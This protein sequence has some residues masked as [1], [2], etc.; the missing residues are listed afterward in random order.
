MQ[1]A[2]ALLKRHG[3]TQIAATLGYLPDAV[4]DYF[5]GG[6]AF[7][8]E[9]RYYV[10]QVP[11]GTA[12]GVR[13]AAD[14]LDET[15]I[16]LSGDGVTDLDIAAA[17]AF[18]RKRRALAT[19]V[20]KHAD[21]P[22][23]Y[24]V[25][26]TDPDG[27]V[28]SFHEKP[29]WSDAIS[30][31]VNT[32]IYI[33]E[34]QALSYIPE[35]R[36]YDFGHDLF[37]ELVR[38]GLPVYGYVTKDY[39]CDVGD[40]RAYLAVHQDALEGRIRVEGLTPPSNRAFQ[41]A[42]ARVDRA[43]VLEGPCLIGANV[44]V[45]P[46]AYVGPY[47]VIGPD[48]V[49][50][51]GASVKRSV[52]WQGARLE[53]GAQARGC[54]LA[55][56]AVM[57]PGAQAYEESVLGTDASIGERALLMPGVKLWPGKHGA[58]GRRLESNLVWGGLSNAIFEGGAIRLL[59]PTQAVRA[60]QAVASALD[61]R[62][63]LLGRCAG[64]WAEALW[65][66]AASGAMAQ[67]ARVL[68]GG[69]CT[70]PQLRCLQALL[71]CDGALWVREDAL[72]PLNAAGAPLLNRDVRA[73]M[74][75]YDRQ[76]FREPSCVG[77]PTVVSVCPGEAAYIARATAWFTADPGRV[78]PVAI[79]A[80]DAQLAALAL[81]AF[82]R[83]GLS[84]RHAEDDETAL[85]PG[86]IGVRL[87]ED[88]E[89]WQLEDETGELSEAE[90]QLLV[91]WTALEL[92]EG[93]LLMPVQATRAAQDLAK[94]Y[95][96]RVEYVAGEGALWANALAERSPI[97]FTLQHD[98]IASALAAISAL[99]HANLTVADWRRSMPSVARRSLSVQVPASRTG[100]VLRAM[101]RQQRG[102]ELGGGLHFHRENGWAW[103]CPDGARSRFR[104]VTEAASEEYARELCDFC[105]KE[106]KRFA[107]EGK[108]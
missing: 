4:R 25:V 107:A 28:R 15:F 79:F 36:S 22:L 2:L 42:S 39:W 50:G 91:A 80:R 11:L 87:S 55:A 1:Y 99:A 74:A 48:C 102:A 66:A 24:G 8:V 73:I 20:L 45:L 27:R 26:L 69:V 18:H 43:A 17:A 89:G 7:G 54:V 12:G 62:E 90:Q 86:E 29:D 53:K 56:G 65:H 32:G 35:G 44:R 31:I 103:I 38:Q 21:N 23:D 85:A 51:E 92:G 30:D 13:Q 78:P 37:P 101:A 104:V 76:D 93:A 63:L 19:L 64:G 57:G 84:P 33:L 60:A 77:V 3:I 59:S 100:L 16:V 67:G 82:T 41:H 61:P 6:D 46:G 88:G 96:A 70:L 75:R 34:P 98:G 9:L 40:V 5:D 47:S 108:A 58:D 94:A 10:E 81:S 105:E 106:L 14:F 72:L 71:G 97:Q 49:V 83:A 95:P 52:L 68:D